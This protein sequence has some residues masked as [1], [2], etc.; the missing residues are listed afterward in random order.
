MPRE[1]EYDKERIE[2]AARIYSTN[3]N[4]ARAIGCTSSSFSRLCRKHGVATP[5]ERRNAQR[6]G[7]RV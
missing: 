6:I 4:A 7:V 3:G 5:R 2:R 1:S